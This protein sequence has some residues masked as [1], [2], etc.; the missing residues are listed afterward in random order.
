MVQRLIFVAYIALVLLASATSRGESYTRRVPIHE[1]AFDKFSRTLMVQG[2]L[3]EPCFSSPRVVGDFDART[4]EVRLQVV[5]D[6]IGDVCVQPV[7]QFYALLVPVDHLARNAIRRSSFH[8]PPQLTIDEIGFRLPLRDSDTLDQTA[9]LL[10]ES[11]EGRLEDRDGLMVL[12][13][14]GESLRLQSYLI[15][16]APYIGRRVAIAGV[17]LTHELPILTHADS[18][19]SRE[20]AVTA[21]RTVL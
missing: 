9:P 8:R 1:I 14:D 17:S 6:R 5:A 2:D 18:S 20:F 16:L 11:I 12:D 3:P 13:R 7:T 15:D 4:N 10:V 19:P 21:I